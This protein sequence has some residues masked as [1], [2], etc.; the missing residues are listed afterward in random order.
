MDLKISEIFRLAC[1]FLFFVILISGWIIFPIFAAFTVDIRLTRTRPDAAGPLVHRPM[2]AGG[3]R[4]KNLV[5]GRHS[6][7][8]D[9]CPR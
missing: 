4:L 6:G 8:R 9:A 2:P 5:S 7:N 1:G 3:R